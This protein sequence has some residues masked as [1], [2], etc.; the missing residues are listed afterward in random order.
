MKRILSILIL[1]GLPAMAE[2]A[3]HVTYSGPHAALWNSI[4]IGSSSLI[5][6]AVFI[7]SVKYLVKPGEKD[8]LHIK[9]IVINEGL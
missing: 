8:P 7:M 3:H 4:I 1:L 9:N 5:V 2:A 6:I